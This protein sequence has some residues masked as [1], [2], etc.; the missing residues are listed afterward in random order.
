MSDE[1]ATGDDPED[2]ND[3][4][5]A[6]EYAGGPAH[7]D[8]DDE[9]DDEAAK[10]RAQSAAAQQNGSTRR[11]TQ[12]ANEVMFSVGDEEDDEHE[13]SRPSR[14]SRADNASQETLLADVNPK[15]TVKND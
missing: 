11:G 7:P 1:V 12:G 4:E 13:Q 9:D 8:S 5:L 14:P 2:G 15:S 3:I 10:K 6:G